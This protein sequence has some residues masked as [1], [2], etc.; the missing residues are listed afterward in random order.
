MSDA[1]ESFKET[2]ELKLL[3]DTIEAAE[4]R[5][6]D[7]TDRGKLAAF[8]LASRD[9]SELFELLKTI[10][11]RMLDCLPSMTLELKGDFQALEG[12][13]DVVEYQ[14]EEVKVDVQGVKADVHGVKVDIKDV[15]ANVLAVHA[16]VD[17]LAKNSDPKELLKKIAAR[18]LHMLDE[19]P[20][21]KSKLAVYVPLEY[22]RSAPTEAAKQQPRLPLQEVMESLLEGHIELH[23]VDRVANNESKEEDTA[24]PKPA[25][26]IRRVSSLKSPSSTHPADKQ[27]LLV[28]GAAGTGKSLFGWR[29][30][31]AWNEICLDAA[32]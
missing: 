15:K 9:K 1:M 3:K 23:Q 30:F 6:K 2:D 27:I 12:R 32:Q 21:V 28:Q 24:P 17:N 14:I 10:R 25:P 19:E 16:K 29:L 18:H 5:V 13:L 4:K 20:D 11:D 31:Q 22:S 26:T 8:M 7:I